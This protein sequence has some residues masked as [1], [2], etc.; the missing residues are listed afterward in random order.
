VAQERAQLTGAPAAP[1]LAPAPT[2]SEGE[3]PPP[4]ASVLEAHK[5][6]VAGVDKRDD[7]AVAQGFLLFLRELVTAQEPYASMGRRLMTAFQQAEDEGELYTLAKNLWIVVGQ[8]SMRP[9][10]KYVARVLAEYYS[11]LHQTVFGEP[12]SLPEDAELEAGEAGEGA[13]AGEG[14]DGEPEGDEQPAEGAA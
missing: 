10:S 9:Q 14:E 3:F 8:K 6:F 5:A 1:K 11:N 7:E 2:Q 4:P 12:R 13:G